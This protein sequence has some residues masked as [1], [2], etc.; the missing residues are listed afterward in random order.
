[1]NP[2]KKRKA[3]PPNR[4]VYWLQHKD[5]SSIRGTIRISIGPEVLPISNKKNEFKDLIGLQF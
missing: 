4:Q 3:L 5:H 1:M 2:D